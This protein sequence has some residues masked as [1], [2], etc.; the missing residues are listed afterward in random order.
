[1]SVSGVPAE[2]FAAYMSTQYRTFTLNGD[3]MVRIGEPSSAMRRLIQSAG[4]DG[5]A[6]LTAENPFSEKLCEAENQVRQTSL[7]EDLMF[8]GAIIL[9][10]AGQGDD[11]TW[12]A[13]T[14]YTAIGITLDEAR[15]L[16]TK[17]QQN[18]I[19]WIDVNGVPE[20]LLLR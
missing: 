16:G 8:L 15:G 20:L 14:S 11:P 6:F 2:L 9:D 17:Y 18:A 3:I 19:V 13:E 12:P 10:G 1:M 4:A 7:R 5:A